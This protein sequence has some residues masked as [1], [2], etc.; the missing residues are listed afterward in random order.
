MSSTS[1]LP[2]AENSSI[3]HPTQLVNFNLART[4]RHVAIIPDGNRRWA[5]KRQASNQEGHREGADVLMDVV[6]AAKELG[7]KYITFY[8]FS[9]ENWERPP[10]EVEAL[11]ALIASY[12][13]VEKEE[14]IA[15]GVRLQTIGDIEKTPEFLQEAILESKEATKDCNDIELILA[16]NYGARDELRRAVSKMLEDQINPQQLT[17]KIMTGYLDTHQWPDP[18]L[19]IRAGG[20][21]RVSNFLLWQ[22][23]YTEI[24]SSPVFWPDFNSMHLLEAVLDY[25]NRDR[26]LGGGQ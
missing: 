15:N 22:L 1:S 2:E 25:Q 19:L 24:Y 16:I 13:V 3:Y 23:S 7:I 26:R 10:I 9:T 20:E 17:E 18:D 11:M 6:R 21:L 4:P 14:M 5:K 12:L 8:A